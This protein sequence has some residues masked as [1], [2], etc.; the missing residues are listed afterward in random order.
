M[1]L[2]ARLIHQVVDVEERIAG[3]LSRPRLDEL[4]VAGELSAEEYYEILT[5]AG[6][7]PNQAH[8]ALL[9]AHHAGAP[10]E[11]PSPPAPAE[12]PHLPTYLRPG[13]RP[14]KSP[15]E[16]PALTGHPLDEE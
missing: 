12:L 4:Y 7:Q 9:D 11:W 1:E 16:G 13:R 15:K 6:W 10:A 2:R 3:T 8:A 5:A 14:A